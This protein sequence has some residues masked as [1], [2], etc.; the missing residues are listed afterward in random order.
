MTFKW[1]FMRGSEWV[2]E[3]KED[4]GEGK[5]SREGNNTRKGYME[6]E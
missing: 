2:D 4:A 3:Q 1:S 5:R 6:E